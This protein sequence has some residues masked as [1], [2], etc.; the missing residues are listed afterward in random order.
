[1]NASRRRLFALPCLALVA[2]AAACGAST[3]SASSKAHASAKSTTS[4]SGTATTPPSAKST[5]SP[6]GTGTTSPSRTGTTSPSG[7]GKSSVSG[8]TA[9]TGLSPTTLPPPPPPPTSGL[10]TLRTV[11]WT[12]VSAPG[13]VCPGRTAPIHLSHGKATIPAPPGVDAPGGV[14]VT[15][16]THVFG[17]LYGSGHDVTAVNV[18]CA[19]AKG[20]AALQLQDSWVL[21]TD[22]HGK[23]EPITTL[24]PRQPASAEKAAG[25]VPYFDSSPGGIAIAPGTVTV[26]E[27]WYAPRDHTCCPSEHVKTVWRAHGT[28]FSSYTE[29]S[30]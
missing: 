28:S 15:V 3:P 2:L 8:T 18:W 6:S 14:T 26:H 17:D 1:M 10:A 21:Y 13:D 24:T 30:G 4:T 9:T 20:T 16:A 22:A 25:H 12:T 19:G 27:L 7:K 5:T 23:V 11:A 29:F